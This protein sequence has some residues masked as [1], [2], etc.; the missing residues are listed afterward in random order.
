MH[1]WSGPGPGEVS[2]KASG[3]GLTDAFGRLRVS[4]PETI[5][6]SK[7]LYDNAPLFWDDSEVSGGSTTSSHSTATASTTIGVGATTAGRRVRQTFMRF[8]YSSGKSQ[9]IMMT[10]VLNESGGGT[11][12]TRGFGYYD[13]DN[14]IFLKDNE[15]TYQVVL[16]TSTSGSAVNT[17]VDQSAWNI[18]PMDGTG[19]SKITIDFSKTQILI[20][21]FE[22]L[23]VGSARIGFVIDGII[24]YVHEFKNANALSLVYMST[25]NL[26]LRYEIENDGTGAASTLEQI[27]STV[28]SEGGTP[29]LGVLR[30]TDSGAISSLQSGTK[31]ALLGIRLK[32]AAVSAT[33]LLESLSLISTTQNDQLHWELIVNPTIQNTFTYSGQT[34]SAVEIAT[35][36]VNNTVT[37]GT[38]IDGGYLST[39]LP[40]SATVPNALRLG[41]AIDGTVDEIV[42][43]AKPITNNIT[44]EASL[45]WREVS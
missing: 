29:N 26:P 33:V 36:S 9:Q 11:G 44:V 4:N 16:R 14:G 41:S 13:D 3:S 32:S 34:N 37:L 15:G 45:T 21:D 6:D 39:A 43:V 10:G 24:Y 12:I 5:F 18:D 17:A 19:L 40:A 31:Y 8:N 1:Q 38:E 20:M 7:Q 25:P 35:G 23:G 42:L 28:I 30:H 27:C 22:W 2:L